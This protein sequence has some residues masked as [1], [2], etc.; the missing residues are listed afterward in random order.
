MK[1][2]GAS[3]LVLS[4]LCATN[5][6]GQSSSASL[7]SNVTFYAKPGIGDGQSCLVGART[8]DDGMNEKPVVYLGKSSNIVIWHASLPLPPHTYQAR[9]TH[10][11][12]TPATLYVLVQGDTQPEQSLSQTLLEVVALN[13][14]TG[15]VTTTK[16][17]DPPN[18]SGANSVW[19]EA[20]DRHFSAQGK[21]L[22]VTGRFAPLSNRDSP[23]GFSLRVPQDLHP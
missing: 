8:D 1:A 17:I 21:D 11:I 10:C 16:A 18:I 14:T 13:R 22:I 5:I 3:L 19:V 12:G 4:I 23:R 15:A 9:A 6:W 7:P 20:G 2:L